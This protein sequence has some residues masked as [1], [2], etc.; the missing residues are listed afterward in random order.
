MFCALDNNNSGF[1][2]AILANIISLN[3]VKNAYAN[4]NGCVV[5]NEIYLTMIRFY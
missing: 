1:V 4:R 2:V 5:S 3:I